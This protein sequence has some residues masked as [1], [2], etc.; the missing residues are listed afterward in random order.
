MCDSL[1][2]WGLFSLALIYTGHVFY[3]KYKNYQKTQ[4]LIKNFQ[5]ICLYVSMVLAN[6]FQYNCIENSLMNKVTNY[7]TNYRDEMLER[8]TELLVKKNKEFRNSKEPELKHFD[9]LSKNSEDEI[10]DND[11]DNDSD[12]ENEN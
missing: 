11:N 5:I 9:E 6:I 2:L 12:D 8:I 3:V 1:P 4:K 7:I 10:D